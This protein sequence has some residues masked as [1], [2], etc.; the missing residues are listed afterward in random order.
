MAMSPC[1][2]KPT[3]AVKAISTAEPAAPLRSTTAVLHWL[4]WL[5]VLLQR[6]LP[7]A[8]TIS[9][10]MP[11]PHMLYLKAKNAPG[12]KLSGLDFRTAA[13]PCFLGYEASMK[14]YSD[15]STAALGPVPV[16]GVVP[17]PRVQSKASPVAEL[18]HTPQK[19]SEADSKL[20]TLPIPCPGAL[21]GASVGAGVGGGCGV[22]GVGSG[23]PAA[24]RGPPD[25]AKGRGGRAARQ[26]W[27]CVGC[28]VGCA[29]GCLGDQVGPGLWCGPWCGLE[30]MVALAAMW[31]RAWGRVWVGG[32]I[33]KES[34]LAAVSLTTAALPAHARLR[35]GRRHVHVRVRVRV[36]VLVRAPA[37][38]PRLHPLGS[39]PCLPPQKMHPGV[40]TMAWA[41]SAAWAPWASCAPWAR[42]I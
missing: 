24:D 14:R 40:W 29:P 30:W 36:H 39:E 16:E 27:Q 15:P 32:G 2:E 28:G 5:P 17:E 25:R 41:S 11:G 42:R 18:L 7:P 19:G 13:S 31:A 4:P 8:L 23:V 12:S 26:G 38:S 22:G 3:S 20:Q 35:G 37:C 21:L 34:G 33:C 1:Q 6:T 10:P 9:L